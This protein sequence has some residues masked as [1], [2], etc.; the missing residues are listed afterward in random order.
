MK[1]RLTPQLL[2]G[3]GG[4]A[5]LLATLSYYSPTFGRLLL[6]LV[7]A[8][9]AIFALTAIVT[10]I[11]IRYAGWNPVNEDDFED[12]VRRTERL[13]ADGLYVDPDENDFLALD[14]YRDADFEQIVADALDD[15]PDLLH[16]ALNNLAVVVSDG[17]AKAGAYGLYHGGTT[18]RSDLPHRIIIYRDTLRRDFGHNADLLQEQITITVRHELAHHLGADELGVRDLGLQ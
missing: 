16:A 13:A 5:F 17:G 7:A 9:A 1:R 2:F 3:L 14:P 12:V 8:L 6:G 11:G 10:A 15:L 4:V 18:A